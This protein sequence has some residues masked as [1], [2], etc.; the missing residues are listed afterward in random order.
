MVRQHDCDTPEFTIVLI[1]Y[2]FLLCRFQQTKVSLLFLWMFAEGSQQIGKREKEKERP[3]T[4]GQ[5]F[6]PALE[7]LVSVYAP[8]SFGLKADAYQKRKPFFLNA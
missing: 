2:G 7:C 5:D 6:L 3:I 4:L 8:L 1:S